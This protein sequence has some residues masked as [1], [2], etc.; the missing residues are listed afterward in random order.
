MKLA[1]RLMMCWIAAISLGTGYAGVS[2]LS[3][4]QVTGA[5]L[6]AAR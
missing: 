2:V 4:S 1:G 3:A 6:V 5:E